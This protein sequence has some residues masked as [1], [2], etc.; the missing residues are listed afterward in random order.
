MF[1]PFSSWIDLASTII[2]L[3]VI[4]VSKETILLF[5]SSCLQTPKQ[6][7]AVTSF[8]LLPSSLPEFSSLFDTLLLCWLVF[9]LLLPDLYV[10][11]LSWPSLIMSRFVLTAIYLFVCIVRVAEVQIGILYVYIYRVRPC[12][13]DYSKCFE[14]LCILMQIFNKISLTC[15]NQGPKCVKCGFPTSHLQR[16]EFKP[17]LAIISRRA[18]ILE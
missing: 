3:Y 15:R 1:F 4:S 13:V 9:M 8:A 12:A 11:C 18:N 16:I 5:S 2:L 14:D 17:R 10:T 7:L 6:L